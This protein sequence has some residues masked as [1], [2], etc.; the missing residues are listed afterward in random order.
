MQGGI[1][2]NNY[3]QFKNFIIRQ[4]LC[5][6]KVSTDS[7]VLGCLSDPAKAERILDIGTGTGLLALQM[8][9]RSCA[10]IDAIEIDLQAATQ[11]LQNFTENNKSQQINLI[12]ADFKSYE[13]TLNYDLIISNPPYYPAGKAPSYQSR[14]LAR[15]TIELPR[16][17]LLAK[18]ASILNP[19]GILALCIPHSDLKSFINQAQRC[20]LTACQITHVQSQSN[21]PPYLAVIMLQ[22]LEAPAILPR[23]EQ[24]LI[25]RDDHG[26]YTEEFRKL[27]QD[28]YLPKVFT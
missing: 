25:I 6:M 18:S 7:V 2:S 23:K 8:A 20:K 11:A 9:Y 5:A 10:R 16:Q 3:F 14:A 17:L 22:H 15:S 13:F 24:C 19:K 1:L 27:T 26:S 12:Q 4:D 28:L 21:I